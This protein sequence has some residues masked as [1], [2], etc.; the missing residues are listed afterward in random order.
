[1]SALMSAKVRVSAVSAAL[2]II[3]GLL[4]LVIHPS[5][6]PLP[7]RPL[8]LVMLAWALFAGAAF[9]LPG[10]PRRWAV[11]LIIIG[12]IAVQVVAVSG[13][14]QSSDD[15]YRYIWDGRVQAHGYD[16]YAYVPSAPQLAH[17]RTP[18]L[19]NHQ[20]PHCVG[21]GVPEPGHPFLTLAPGCTRINRPAVPTIYPPV[22][23]FYFLALH[24]VTPV[25]AGS[26]PVQAGAGACAVLVTLLLLL[27]LRY[28]RRDLRWAALWAWCPTVALEAGNNAHV[29]VV[30]VLLTLAAL[31]VLA[32]RGASRRGALFGGALLGLAIAT[33]VTPVLVGPAVL[34]RRW[35]SVVAASAGAVIV[36]YLPH[37]LAVGSKVIGYLPGYLKEEGFDNGSR[38]ALISLF[39]T[40]KL[41]VVIAVLLLA[42]T[43]LAVI[44]FSDPDRPW[45]AAVVMTGM[46][47]IVTTPKYQ[48]YAI[49]LVM[50]VVLD[51]RPEW[52][53][54]AAASYLGAEPWLGRW[55]MVPHAE[56]IGYGVA[57]LF[58]A[59]V[60]F[61]RWLIA[62]YPE[63]V[64]RLGSRGTAEVADVAAAAEVANA[65][66]EAHV[67][68]VT[69]VPAEAGVAKGVAE[70]DAAGKTKE[71]AAG[72]S[73]AAR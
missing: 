34:K 65:A 67:S 35:A 17:I 43:G 47:L 30:A 25:Y 69:R 36:V 50:L 22:A 72:E 4:F 9:L 27:G 8:P 3:C 11:A 48:W 51:S 7:L 42:V 57:A 70:G 14:P 54:L 63:P 10:I 60:S 15:L 58:I 21:P 46:A 55:R 26:T 13:P 5:A 16:P 20:A 45:R 24:Y 52:L 59:L 38:F 6:D 44:R 29:D 40:G 66:G 23:E 73:V 71:D 33:K 32:R 41:A 2:V 18:F 64:I 56:A 39:A 49:L 28:L 12:G 19:F 53:A 62:R 37:V 61:L 1:M 68:E 31:L